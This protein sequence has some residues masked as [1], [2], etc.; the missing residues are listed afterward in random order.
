MLEL[1]ARSN[2]LISD[3]IF[4]IYCVT[5]LLVVF[6]LLSK[7]KITKILNTY[8]DRREKSKIPT[9]PFFIVLPISMILGIGLH[10]FILEY[11]ILFS[12]S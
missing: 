12:S 8:R 4:I 11:I 5:I 3:V 10:I 9:W 7:K 1:F 6:N 2:K